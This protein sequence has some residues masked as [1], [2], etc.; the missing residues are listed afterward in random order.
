MRRLLRGLLVENLTIKIISL[1]IGVGL[2]LYVNRQLHPLDRETAVADVSVANVASEL[3]P[4]VIPNQL[5]VVI[6][7]QKDELRSIQPYLR[8][9]EAVV[10]ATGK[11]PGDHVMPVELVGLPPN[12][13]QNNIQISPP[14]VTLK[15]Q[16]LASKTLP[17]SWVP[18][19][20]PPE[21]ITIAEPI[22]RPRSV[23][24]EGVEDEIQRITKA[25][26]EVD[27]AKVQS[28]NA[29]GLPVRLYDAGGARLHRPGVSVEPPLVSVVVPVTDVLT[30]VV[31]V[32]PDVQ[33]TGQGFEITQVRVSPSVVTLSG[34][35]DTLSPVAYVS[36]ETMTVDGTQEKETRRLNL[37]LPSGVRVIGESKV[38]VTVSTRQNP[39]PPAATPPPEQSQPAKTDSKA[40]AKGERRR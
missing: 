3:V 30:K 7:G 4:R 40:Q 27:L 36:S 19:S 38:E 5:Q 35:T 6:W 34:A 25:Q 28:G 17:V 31:P 9:L 11:G 16:K 22:I 12:L 24:V 21:G 15:L 32:I 29:S 37:V 26:V 10:D 2:W 1:L 8:D 20:P 13:S 23:V 18:S 14:N 39:T 33:T